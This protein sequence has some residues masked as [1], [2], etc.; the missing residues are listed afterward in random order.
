MS[1][2]SSRGNV[3][4]VYE[5]QFS[6]QV[7]TESASVEA[8]I[9]EMETFSVAIDNGIEEWHPFED[10][11][12]VKRL[13]TAKSIT[14]TV[15]GK[16]SVG[17]LG[18]DYIASLFD[19][20]GTAA[21]AR[22]TWNFPDGTQ[23]IFDK[24][25]INVT[26]IGSGDSTNVGPLE[27][28]VMSNGRPTI[29]SAADL[30]Y[31]AA[32]ELAAL[33][34]HVAPTDEGYRLTYVTAAEEES[35]D[36]YNGTCPL[37]TLADGE[38][39]DEITKNGMYVL[40]SSYTYG[41]DVPFTNGGWLFTYKNGRSTAFR[42][43]V[44]IDAALGR[45]L[46]RRYSSSAW[47]AWTPIK[48]EK[49]FHALAAANLPS[50]DLNNVMT[51]GLFLIAGANT[52][53]NS[54]LT[55]SGGFLFVFPHSS[56]LCVQI[57][58]DILLRDLYIRRRSASGWS[59][60]RNLSSGGAGTYH[61]F[62]DSLMSGRKSDGTRTGYPIPSTIAREVGLTV[63]NHGIT[64]Q[65]LCY[66]GGVESAL[67]TVQAASITDADLVTLA[68]GRNDISHETAL[69]TAA[70]AAGANTLVGQ[71]KAIVEHILAQAPR[72]QIVIITPAR[73]NQPLEYRYAA[74]GFSVSEMH[75]LFK[76][77]FEG[78]YYIPVIGYNE[79]PMTYTWTTAI[80]TNASSDYNVHPTTDAAYMAL[81]NYLAG[82]VGTY[83]KNHNLM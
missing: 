28:Q 21:Q 52:Y 8:A 57:A 19:K 12:W 60:W 51:P 71:M 61:A 76:E 18:N 63:I 70:D 9:S 5:N 66:D 69:G 40:N 73:S 39:I 26:N 33:G 1:R 54:P 58:A 67:A 24:A 2:R 55:A 79:T 11:G 22:F 82:R 7:V 25:V 74:S 65:A 83:Y 43:Q 16:R 35:V 31:E 4:P 13:L 75:A 32:Q 30:D 27:F 42:L 49:A 80:A 45:Y 38:N 56:T 34:L 50:G 77:V 41:G 64:G 20:T 3:F 14:I 62:G 78:G 47:T 37:G 36:L 6:V 10:A 81:G 68:W 46:V 23:V 59:A 44:A 72:C 29:Y 53:T 48:D 15:N 17:D